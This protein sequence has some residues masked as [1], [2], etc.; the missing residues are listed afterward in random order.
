MF[1][2]KIIALLMIIVLLPIYL[3]LALLVYYFIGKPIIFKQQ[4]LGLNAKPFTLY[5]F[6]TMNNN[7]DSGG[8]LLRDGLRLSKFGLLLR[9]TSLDEL[10]NLHNILKNDM[11]FIG[12]RPLLVRYLPLYNKE[13]KRRHEVKPGLTGL[14]QVNYRNTTSWEKRL[15]L[16]VWY[17]DNKSFWLDVKILLSTIKIV[18]TSC[19]TPTKNSTIMSPF[20]GN[21]S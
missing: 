7:K 11:S 16:D 5:K 15:K 3:I 2:N 21:K 19:V 1:I 12:P 18:F 4:R 14:A 6:R 9:A 17:V 10:P 13:Q 20:K 8:N